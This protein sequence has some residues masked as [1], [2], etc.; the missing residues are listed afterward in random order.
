MSYDLYLFKRNNGDISEQDVADYLNTNLPLSTNETGRQW[1]YENSE[2][3]VYILISWMS[4]M[5]S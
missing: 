5:K 1:D 2:T 4:Q 3:G